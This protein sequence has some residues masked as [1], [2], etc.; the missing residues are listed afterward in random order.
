MRKRRK[1][2]NNEE[3]YHSTDDSDADDTASLIHGR[4]RTDMGISTGCSLPLSRLL[5]AGNER[6]SSNVGDNR[7]EFND[8]TPD[9]S[10]KRIVSTGFDHATHRRASLDS[11]EREGLMRTTAAGAFLMRTTA[12]GDF[13][14]DVPYDLSSN[15]A[16]SEAEINADLNTL[17]GATVFTEGVMTSSTSFPRQWSAAQSA[18]SPSFYEDSL[19]IAP[20]PQ[21]MP[22]QEFLAMCNDNETPPSNGAMPKTNFAMKTEMSRR[23]H[24]LFEIKPEFMPMVPASL[25]SLGFSVQPSAAESGRMPAATKYVARPSLDLHV[26]SPSESSEY[27]NSSEESVC[28]T[29]YEVNAKVKESPSSS[30]SASSSP[31]ACN[32]HPPIPAT[33][34][35][36]SSPSPSPIVPAWHSP[37]P[38][39]TSIVPDAPAEAA[40]EV[41]AEDITD[42]SIKVRDP[43]GEWST[44]ALELRAAARNKA[45]KVFHLTDSEAGDLK[46]QGR[47]WKQGTAQRK[48]LAKARTLLSTTSRTVSKDSEDRKVVEGMQHN[49]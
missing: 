17:L 13:F 11:G 18:S 47:R 34:S 22:A 9:L 15:A 30:R 32:P 23:N 41:K 1:L 37:S 39:P 27:P 7:H 46:I 42:Q 3:T 20:M 2:A 25:S 48:Y 31:L 21:S 35:V 28:S 44:W 6:G 10:L 14:S 24:S 19:E 12:A 49:M 29:Y 5:S 8:P 36:A 40:I 43:Q 45:V 16:S 33:F 38:S 4:I 26:P